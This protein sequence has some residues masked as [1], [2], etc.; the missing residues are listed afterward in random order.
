MTFIEPTILDE[1]NHFREYTP[2]EFTIGSLKEE[3]KIVHELVN[4]LN[5]EECK[6][7]NT[8]QSNKVM[9]AISLHQ[10]RVKTI[11]QILI[12]GITSEPN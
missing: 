5:S 11:N 9:A 2:L 4:F 8:L 12:D 10:K 1:C 6:K 7:M 3:Q